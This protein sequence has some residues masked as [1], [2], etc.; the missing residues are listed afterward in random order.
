MRQTG[1]RLIRF[2]RH[3]VIQES[4][5]DADAPHLMEAHLFIVRQP[6]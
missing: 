2:I 1:V 3:L 4:M 5:N 6:S